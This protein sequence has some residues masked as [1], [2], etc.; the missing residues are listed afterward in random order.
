MTFSAGTKASYNDKIEGKKTYFN[1][2]RYVQYGKET[3]VLLP[4][5]RKDF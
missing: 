3:I 4:K 1:N 5:L 2:L